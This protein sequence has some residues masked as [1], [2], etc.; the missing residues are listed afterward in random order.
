MLW[1]SRSAGARGN[2]Q[3]VGTV[4]RVATVVWGRQRWNC[5]GGKGA[6]RGEG[7]KAGVCAGNRN[8]FNQPKVARQVTT[9]PSGQVKRRAQRRQVHHVI[10][11]AGV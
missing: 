1:G 7:V 10:R 5:S 3:N 11:Q 8:R 9:E 6:L 2:G 4:A